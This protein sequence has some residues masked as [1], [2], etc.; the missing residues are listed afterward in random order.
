MSMYGSLSWRHTMYRHVAATW[1]TRRP[2]VKPCCSASL[3]RRYA[4][5]VTLY[6]RWKWSAIADISWWPRAAELSWPSICGGARERGRSCLFAEGS[7]RLGTCDQRID[8]SRTRLGTCDQR[9]MTR[10]SGCAVEQCR[11]GTQQ[12]E[13]RMQMDGMCIQ[14]RSPGHTCMRMP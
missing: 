7:T 11:A 5:S 4:D 6:V 3:Y 9:A 10:S 1:L 12:L 14:T 2:R 13:M 8:Q